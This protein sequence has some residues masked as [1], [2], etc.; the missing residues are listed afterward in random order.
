M[1]VTLLLLLLWKRQ[2]TGQVLTRTKLCIC[3]S[4]V[5]HHAL[6][7]SGA[8]QVVSSLRIASLLMSGRM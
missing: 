8:S 1:A 2:A 7:N 5:I 6:Y 3:C 4:N